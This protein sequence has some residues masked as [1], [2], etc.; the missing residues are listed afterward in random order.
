MSYLDRKCV[1]FGRLPNARVID[2]SSHKGRL[3]LQSTAVFERPFVVNFRGASQTSYVGSF[4]IFFDDNL[5]ETD[6][7]KTGCV[8]LTPS[9]QNFEKDEDDKVTSF[10]FELELHV[11]MPGARKYQ[12]LEAFANGLQLTVTGYLEPGQT[13]AITL[14]DDF[15]FQ[16]HVIDDI[17]LEWQLGC[18]DPPSWYKT[19]LQQAA[20]ASFSGAPIRRG[21]QVETIYKEISQA[22]AEADNFKLPNTEEVEL[23]VNLVSDARSALRP[24]DKGPVEELNPYGSIWNLRTDDFK[25]LVS[26]IPQAEAKSLTEKYDTLWSHFDV[27][28]VLQL[29][30]AKFGAHSKG[31]DPK[32]DEIEAA[33]GKLM[34][35]NPELYSETLEDVLLNALIY[36]EVIGFARYAYSK[37]ELLGKKI[38]SPIKGVSNEEPDGW[39]RSVGALARDLSLETGKVALTFAVAYLITGQEITPSWIVTTGFTLYRWLLR[40]W[41]HSRRTGQKNQIPLVLDMA[42]L[43]ALIAKPGFSPEMARQ[44]LFRVRQL[45]GI[46]SPAVNTLLE[47]RITRHRKLLHR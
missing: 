17:H 44:E 9:V 19:V 24:Y 42:R 23:I 43:H 37:E 16:T 13:R 7:L 40:D 28:Q 4:N 35:L 8:K 29:G 34:E 6:H 26:K 33:V 20:L 39:W 10:T 14:S 25:E 30:E 46:F 18:I 36:A 1:A 38:W 11:R 45:G 5:V 47:R 12:Y 27:M 15:E 41:T 2:S 32:V 22:Y 31:F 21:S 3:F